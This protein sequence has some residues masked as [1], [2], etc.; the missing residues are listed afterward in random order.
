LVETADFVN[1]IGLRAISRIGVIL[2]L[3]LEANRLRA[4]G[5]YEKTGV[6]PSKGLAFASAPR[7]GVHAARW[8]FARRLTLAQ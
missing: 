3:G 5:H 8:N 2:E 4:V 1:G 7:F 6:A